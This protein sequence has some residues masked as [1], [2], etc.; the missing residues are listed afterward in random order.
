MFGRV[1]W[2]RFERARITQYSCLRVFNSTR[3]NTILKVREYFTR[4][5]RAERRS[6]RRAYLL[7]GTVQFARN[8][9][10]YSTKY[11]HV[12]R[13]ILTHRGRPIL[14]DIFS[15]FT[16][17]PLCYVPYDTV[18]R[19]PLELLL[20]L[21][22]NLVL[23]R[24]RIP[25]LRHVLV[26]RGRPTGLSGFFDVTSVRYSDYADDGRPAQRW[27]ASSTLDIAM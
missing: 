3:R 17:R 20:L 24:S 25:P 5:Y 18:K 23:P 21:R 26:V 6:L 27:W 14:Y 8:V 7:T 16:R 1:V 13:N 19:P 9:L 4:G 22:S 12:I 11:V 2:N 15:F 10:K